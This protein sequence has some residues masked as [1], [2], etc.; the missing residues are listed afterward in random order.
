MQDFSNYDAHQHAFNRAALD[1]SM[2]D[3][4]ITNNVLTGDF[5]LKN[6]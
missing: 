5:V 1:T 6:V 4:L 2:Y 3:A